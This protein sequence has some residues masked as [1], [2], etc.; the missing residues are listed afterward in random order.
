VA[1]PDGRAGVWDGGAEGR[2]VGPGAVASA[3]E[4]EVMQWVTAQRDLYRKGALRPDRRERLDRAGFVWSVHDKHWVDTLRRFAEIP[5][6]RRA[7]ALARDPSLCSWVGQQCRLWRSNR[8]RADRILQL[9]VVPAAQ[10][11]PRRRF[12]PC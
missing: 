1:R 12:R 10:P 11:T 2:L 9:E 7:D 5:G 8:L 6:E 3:E 4:R